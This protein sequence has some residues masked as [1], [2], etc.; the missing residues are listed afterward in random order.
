MK[1]KKIIFL[2][3]LFFLMSFLLFLPVSAQVDS[4]I[5]NYLPLEA[6][7]DGLIAS[8]MEE[9]NAPGV[10]LS[11]VKDGE[12]ILAKGYGFSDI[13]NQKTVDPEKTMFRPGS[14]TKLFV[15]TAVMQMVEQGKIDLDKDINEYLDFRIPYSIRGYKD[16]LPRETRSEERRVG[17]ECIVKCRSRWS[18]YH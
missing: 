10:T 8:Q 12:I 18:P 17:K 3:S 2:I 11:I 14:V 7:F 13:E 5:S 1:N 6:F 4:G 15:W 16:T 9:Y